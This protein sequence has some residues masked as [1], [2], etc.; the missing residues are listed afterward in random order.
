MEVYTFELKSYNLVTYTGD[1]CATGITLP[2]P[3]ATNP[4]LAAAFTSALV[5]CELTYIT[6]GEEARFGPCHRCAWR[7]S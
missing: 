1:T 4:L 6:K 7:C 3:P 2:A 5:L